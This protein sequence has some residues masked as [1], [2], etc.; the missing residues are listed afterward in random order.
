MQKILEVT[1]YTDRYDPKDP[2]DLSRLENVQELLSVASQFHDIDT[3]LENISLIQ[4]DAMADVTTERKEDVVTLM[5]IHSAKGLEFAVVYMV[6]MEEGLFPHS[7]SLLDKE[8]M[9]EERRLAYVGITRAKQKLYMTYA[10]KRFVY[11]SIT[12]AMPSR[13]IHDIPEHLVE[14]E[15]AHYS[16]P[17]TFGTFG[18]YADDYNRKPTG[19]EQFN[20]DVSL[21]DVLSGN[22]DVETFLKK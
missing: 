11:G 1:Q 9:E 15:M 13:F 20:D 19:R 7:R 3:F 10:R 5:S 18:Q 21:D 12:A 8:Q 14:Q 17:S 22:L 16:R 4:D 2:D 6:G